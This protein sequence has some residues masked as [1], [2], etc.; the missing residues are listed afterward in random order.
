MSEEVCSLVPAPWYCAA[1]RL[2]SVSPVEKSDQWMPSAP[3]TTCVTAIA[4]PSARPSPRI[5][6]ATRP[7]RVYERMTPRTISQRERPFFEIFGNA[8]KELAADARDDRDGHDRE[9]ERGGEDAR[10][11]GLALEDGEEAEG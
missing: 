11:R 2:A 1:I 8:E 10:G 3:P 9:H 7:G 4:S 6:A 5:T